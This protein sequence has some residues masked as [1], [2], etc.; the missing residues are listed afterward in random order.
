[1]G[2]TSRSASSSRPTS[3]PPSDAP[4]GVFTCADHPERPATARCLACGRLVCDQ[5]GSSVD[6][7][8]YCAEHAA[9][10][11]EAARIDWSAGDLAEVS[12]RAIGYGVDAVLLAAAGALVALYVLLLV[13]AYQ[14]TRFYLWTAGPFAL[15]LG[16]YCTLCVGSTGRTIGHALFGLRVVRS[17]G[18]S[19]SYARAF[20]RWIGYLLC[21]ATAFIGFAIALWDPKKQGLHDKL[22]DTVVVGAH[23]STAVKVWASL[24][25]LGAIAVGAF[26]LRW[27]LG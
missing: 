9:E 8:I 12:T 11:R 27:L 21:T 10:R 6:G 18:S 19:V 4:V 22:A 2:E 23:A 1:M 13:P 15:L 16:V 5:C 14:L 17:D 7:R 24:V 25:L 20:V 26:L 3:L